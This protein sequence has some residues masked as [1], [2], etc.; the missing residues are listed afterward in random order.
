MDLLAKHAIQTY[1][2]TYITV[3]VMMAVYLYQF[4]LFAEIFSHVDDALLAYLGLAKASS[5][6]WNQNF[7]FK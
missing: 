1:T 6:V 5:P 3:G 7:I 4:S 2:C